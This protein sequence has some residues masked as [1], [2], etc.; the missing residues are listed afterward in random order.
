MKKIEWEFEP[1]E[2]DGARQYSGKLTGKGL[3]IGIAVSRFNRH[4]TEPLVKSAVERLR[5]LGVFPQDITVVW[6][7]GAYELPL[8]L[9][10]M[11]SRKQHD[12]LIALGAVVWGETA[13]AELIARQVTASLADIARRYALPVIDGVVTAFN[14]MQARA[15]CLSE[16][17]SRGWYAASA[18][19]EMVNVLKN[20]ISGS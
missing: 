7:P 10:I 6:V 13:H 16:E 5:A 18:A 14:E 19:V 17:S 11:A 4:L 8:M 20:L 1:P 3:K 9:E 12:A 15:R 2:L